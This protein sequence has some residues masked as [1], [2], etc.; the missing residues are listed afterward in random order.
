M[1]ILA[2]HTYVG[3]ACTMGWMPLSKRPANCDLC[4]GCIRVGFDSVLCAHAPCRCLVLCSHCATVSK[5]VHVTMDSLLHIQVHDSTDHTHSSCW[6]YSTLATYI[7]WA[8]FI[9]ITLVAAL[10]QCMPVWASPNTPGLHACVLDS[11]QGPL[12]QHNMQKCITASASCGVAAHSVAGQPLSASC[13]LPAWPAAPPASSGL[14]QSPQCPAAQTSSGP[15]Q[16]AVRPCAC[17]WC[18]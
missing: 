5:S 3:Y 16:Q 8:Q 13:Q 4:E 7:E 12:Q 17:I 11:K 18:T 14:Q 2:V 10:F 6:Q 15:G 9:H 1:G